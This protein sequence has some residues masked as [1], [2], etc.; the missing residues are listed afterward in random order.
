MGIL[1]DIKYYHK[2][3]DLIDIKTLEVKA[4][5]CVATI[6]LGVSIYFDTY[7][8]YFLYREFYIKFL[9]SAVGALLTLLAITFAGIALIINIL[10]PDIVTGIEKATTKNTVPKLMASFKFFVF[11]IFIVVCIFLGILWLNYIPY[12]FE[13]CKYYGIIFLSSYLFIFIL[14]YN[15]GLIGNTIDLFFIRNTY[16][17]ID[18]EDKNF[19]E[20]ANEVRI[21]FVMSFLLNENDS[22]E[23]L[24]NHLNQFVDNSHISENDK[25][26]L[27]KYFSQYYYGS[28]G[29]L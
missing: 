7:E 29:A 24:I 10:K 3:S 22:P 8:F 17:A 1:N 25:E 13:K 4:A 23:I 19:I 16:E 21:D 11:L 12:T 26:K 14:G 15:I 9:A 28:N 18:K 27:K 2:I 6:S 5:I 20:L